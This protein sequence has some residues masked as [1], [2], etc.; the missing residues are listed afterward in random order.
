[1]NRKRNENTKS[2][3]DLAKAGDAIEKAK[4]HLARAENRGIA[5]ASSVAS[6]AILQLDQLE[7][8][9]MYAADELANGDFPP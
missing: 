1:M 3:R 2:V 4:R 5:P 8:K 7:Q 9:I 6:Y